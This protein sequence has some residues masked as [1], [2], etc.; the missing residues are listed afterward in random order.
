MPK[1]GKRKQTNYQRVQARNRKDTANLE[2]YAAVLPIYERALP[3]RQEYPPLV[4]DGK[5]SDPSEP[6]Y[7]RRRERERRIR[8]GL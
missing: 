6:P 5:W 1:S 4:R 3:S 7:N 2:N 8:Q